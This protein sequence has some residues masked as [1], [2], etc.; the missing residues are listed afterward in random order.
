M[1]ERARV[2][3][4]RRGWVLAILLDRPEKRNAADFRLLREL[5]AA[6][7]MLDRDPTLR[8]GLVLAE[9][10]HF[11][12]GLDLADIG[13][14]LTVGGLDFVPEG[15]LDPWG[16]QTRPVTKP[17][18]M[19]V[20]G[21]CL[22]LGIELALASDVVLTEESARFG[23]IEVTRGILPFGGATLRFPRVAGWGNAL[24]W[25]LTGDEFDATEAL[26]IGLVQEIVADGTV[27]HAADALAARI[28]A[29]APRAVQA[30]LANAR[31]AVAGSEAEAAAALPEELER[32]AASDDAAI[33]MRAFLARS[34]AEFTGR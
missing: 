3:V 4:E 13:P 24:R 2:R 12:A 14:R 31:L 22:T 28:A 9:G 6:Y 33:G 17:V 21:T 11:T 30:A 20:Q 7:G 25:I 27:G 5:A 23:Q 19:G 16:L 8:V 1:S 32:L 10:A 26:R 15:G 18:V 29:Q 34:T